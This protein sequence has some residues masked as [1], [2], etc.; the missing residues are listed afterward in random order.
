MLMERLKKIGRALIGDDQAVTPL[1]LGAIHPALLSR[2]RSDHPPRYWRD[3]DRRSGNLPIYAEPVVSGGA[4]CAQLAS[5]ISC[6]IGTA[7]R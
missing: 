3:Y 4:N 2:I 5:T 1:F 7:M 6:G